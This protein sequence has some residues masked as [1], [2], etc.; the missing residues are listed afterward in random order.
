[1]GVGGVGGE[2]ELSMWERVRHQFG[3]SKGGLDGVKRLLQRGRPVQ[4]LWI[5]FK[6]LRQGLECAGGSGQETA[7][8]VYHTQEMLELLRVRQPGD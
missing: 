8:E 4:H 3:S 7:V 2:G 1:M 5:T 6:T